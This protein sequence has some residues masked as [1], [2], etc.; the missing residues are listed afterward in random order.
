M[1]LGHLWRLGIVE[2]ARKA[3][4]KSILR[5]W[6]ANMVPYKATYKLV[7]VLADNG[8]GGGGRVVVS[9]SRRSSRRS[10]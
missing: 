6:R 3:C 8:W 5:R 9:S 4:S 1:A 10:R 7:L 2:H